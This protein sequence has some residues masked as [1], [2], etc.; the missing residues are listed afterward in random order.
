MQVQVRARSFSS[1]CHSCCPAML[2]FVGPRSLSPVS[3]LLPLSDHP[4]SSRACPV[5][6]PS[7][8]QVR[9]LQGAE[10]DLGRPQRGVPQHQGCQHCHGAWGVCVR[11]RLCVCV[12]ESVCAY[13][14]VCVRAWCV[15]VRGGIHCT[16]PLL[17]RLLL[18]HVLSVAV[19]YLRL[20]LLGFARDCGEEV[21]HPSVTG[22]PL[23]CPSLTRWTAR[24]TRRSA[25]PRR[26][27]PSRR[28]PHRRRAAALF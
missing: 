3:F 12:R 8:R 25:W 15:R 26:P 20:L 28:E 7:P 14:C 19:F 13:A 16:L 2:D 18:L 6:A 24:C 10:A 5:P 9:P 4:C 23:L 27:A 11:V 22:R 17:M 21:L 1:G